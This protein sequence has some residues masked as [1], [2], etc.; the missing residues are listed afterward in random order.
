MRGENSL[1][2]HLSDGKKVEEKVD[3]C[4]TRTH[5]SQLYMMMLYQVCLLA[6]LF[7]SVSRASAYKGESRGFESRRSPLFLSIRQTDRQTNR[8]AGRQ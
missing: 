7:S 4:G 2:Y 8:R 3:S 6:G 1:P 5:D